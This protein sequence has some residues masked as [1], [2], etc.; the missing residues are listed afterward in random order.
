V[1]VLQFDD[2]W[3]PIVGNSIG[4]DGAR[5]LAKALKVNATLTNLDLS[6]ATHASF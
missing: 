1:S 2:V 3:L 5:E 4:V 6:G